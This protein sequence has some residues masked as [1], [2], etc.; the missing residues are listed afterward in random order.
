ML[1]PTARPCQ[2]PTMNVLNAP[3]SPASLGLPLLPVRA[4][5]GFPSPAED[6]YGG[7]D[8]LDL[9]RL[10]VANPLATFFVQTDTG[11][12]MQELG[13][14]PGDTLVVDRSKTAKH[15]DIVLAVWDGGFVVKQLKVLPTHYELHSSNPLNKPI[16]LS[17]DTELDVW[18]VV[19][20]TFHRV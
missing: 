20:W 2:Y 19:T 13:I 6:F 1:P 8:V 5:C 14:Y 9:N 4:T 7:S 3:P 10:C 12:S 15:L 16:V 11:T 18:G 17:P